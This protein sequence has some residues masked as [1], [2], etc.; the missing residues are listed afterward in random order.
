M[1]KQDETGFSNQSVRSELISMKVGWQKQ[2]VTCCRNP[3]ET[4]DRGGIQCFQRDEV[5]LSSPSIIYSCRREG[6]DA[7]SLPPTTGTG[8]PEKATFHRPTASDCS[9]W[10]LNSDDLKTHSPVPQRDF[11]W[12]SPV[13]VCLCVCVSPVE[14]RPLFC[15][16]I[17]SLPSF[18]AVR[19]ALFSAQPLLWVTPS[20]PQTS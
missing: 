13:C 7:A 6:G 10:L 9:L 12:L 18:S 4:N 15:T 20:V 19:L 11:Y 14:Q 8:R 5:G 16:L 2:D 3:P 1:F 17:G